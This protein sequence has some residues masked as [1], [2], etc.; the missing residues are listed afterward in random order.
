MCILCCSLV[1][2]PPHTAAFH[3]NA[4]HDVQDNVDSIDLSDNDLTRLD[5]F[6]VLRRLSWL[7]LAGN[8]VAR[9]GDELGNYLPNLR[10]L[11]LTGNRLATLAE[12]DVLASLASLEALSLLHNPV[13]RRPH[14]RAY[15]ISRFP[16]LRVL[17]FQR[18]K[19]KERS[20]AH[21]F[22]NSKAGRAFVAEVAQAGRGAGTASALGTAAGLGV[23]GPPGSLASA[24]QRPPPYTAD[25]LAAIHAAIS[26]A[27]TGAEIE[28]LERYLSEGLVPPELAS[29]A[30]TDEGNEV[31]TASDSRAEAAAGV[32]V[33]GA[34]VESSGDTSGSC[35]DEA[36]SGRMGSGAAVAVVSQV[37]V[38]S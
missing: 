6:P 32:T 20:A 33:N 1:H 26:A 30:A 25:Q 19:R 2:A 24:P 31:A 15:V 8:R 12:I 3:I 34:A 22:M 16:Q 5:N 18:V 14:Y 4:R 21:K 9:V 10:T 7:L 28:R 29:V 17:D 27:A 37:S 38:E 35:D 36:P 23:S 13:T 11:V